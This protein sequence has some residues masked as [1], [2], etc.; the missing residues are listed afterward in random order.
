MSRTLTGLATVAIL[1]GLLAAA[2]R[3]Q[4][5]PNPSSAEGRGSSPISAGPSESAPRTH[6]THQLSSVLVLNGGETKTETAKKYE[7]KTADISAI[8]VSEGAQLT[9]ISPTIVTNG[10]T[11]S[12]NA[13]RAFGLN[14]AVLVA[15]GGTLKISGGSIVT[16]GVGATGAYTTNARSSAILSGLRIVTT[17]DDSRGVSASANATTTLTDVDITTSGSNSAAIATDRGS[18]TITVIGCTA[19]TSGPASPGILSTG[20]ITV[21]GG[22]FTA[23]SSEAAA[24]EDKSSLA[25]K[26]THLSG[27]KRCGV[28]I[29]RRCP[30]DAKGIEGILV[31]EGGSIFAQEGPAIYVV[32]ATGV[33]SLTNVA[34][35]AKSGIL[36]KAGAG[37]GG[38][39][40]ADGSHI[41]LTASAQNLKGDLVCD[42]VSTLSATLQK[43]STLTG[44]ISGAALTLDATSSWNVTGDS[45]VTSLV[46]PS[47][48]SGTTL[49]NIH[50]NGHSV[51]Y[52]AGLPENQWLSRKTY[53]LADGGQ[54][55]PMPPPT[56]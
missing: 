47:A 23:S 24:L 10:D 31:M 15:Q 3:A 8:S 22:R 36:V 35:T 11:S 55:I 52:D 14:A 6:S 46:D 38:S 49:P 50:G 28:I 9:L 25:L 16:S 21:T 43:N 56:N 53:V 27:Q 42:R 41:H 51:R 39:K 20:A 1:V 2:A 45:A 18:G 34:I 32:G 26:N 5:R 44:T 29:Y 33:I 37:R 54:L 12:D 13:S 17:G 40:A 19:T 7:S 4:I 30:G 48:S